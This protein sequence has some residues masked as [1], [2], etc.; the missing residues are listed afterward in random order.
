MRN[1]QNPE[2]LELMN[3]LGEYYGRALSE[4]LLDIYWESLKNHELDD[5]A[6]ALQLHINDPDTGQYFPRMA[7]I[8]RH[9]GGGN[10]DRALVAWSKVDKAVR[11]IGPYRSV[12][13]DD[14]MIHA[15]IQDM[16]GWVGFSDCKLIE[17]PH[18][19]NEFVKR[20]RGYLATGAI[21]HYPGKLIGTAESVNNQRGLPAELVDVAMVGVIE[22]CL[23][24]M[25]RGAASADQK[26]PVLINA[27]MTAK[28]LQFDKARQPV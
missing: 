4:A 6:R 12:V 24:V 3:G 28:V 17:W 19:Q 23:D 20:Y 11:T 7:D 26:I 16:G 8:T 25:L 1:E 14:A 9:L 15:V 5:V 2:F 22:H 13:F 21:G 27:P 10:A 18:K